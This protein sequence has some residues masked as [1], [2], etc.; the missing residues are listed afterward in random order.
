MRELFD[1]FEEDYN[2][3]KLYLRGEISNDI[4]SN[5]GDGIEDPLENEDDSKIL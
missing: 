2:S 1:F 4:S 5:S 3:M